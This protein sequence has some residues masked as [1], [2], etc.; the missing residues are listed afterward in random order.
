MAKPKVLIKKYSDRRLYDST[1]SRYVKLEDIA[2]MIR[3]GREVEVRDAR[4]GK[5]LTC[6][7]LTQIV[8]E[9]AREGEAVLPVQLLQQMVMASDRATRD[10]LSSYLHGTLDLYTKARETF[11]SQLAGAKQAV[12]NPVEFV[13][14]LMGKDAEVEQLR[15]RVKELEARLAEAGGPASRPRPKS[16]G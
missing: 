16:R 7:I 2:R 5:D 13:R 3:E 9:D 6:A 1:A 8:M 12:T 14:N 11:E 15:R 4:T 10:F